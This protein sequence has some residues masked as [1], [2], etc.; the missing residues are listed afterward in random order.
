MLILRTP[1]EVI[2]AYLIAM[3]MGSLGGSLWRTM[4]WVQS[5]ISTVSWQVDVGVDAFTVLVWS[6][7]FWWVRAR[8]DARLAMA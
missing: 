5:M 3:S 1:G 4:G 8:N 7:V 2:C 6:L